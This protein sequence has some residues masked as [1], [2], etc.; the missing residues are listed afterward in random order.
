MKSKLPVGTAALPCESPARQ[1]AR[2]RKLRSLLRK[3][4]G[5]TPPEL[6]AS[7]WPGYAE[8]FRSEPDFRVYE[9]GGGDGRHG[10]R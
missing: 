3:G 10:T 8:A 5:L 7:L 6:Q 1:A 4:L 2:L 9:P